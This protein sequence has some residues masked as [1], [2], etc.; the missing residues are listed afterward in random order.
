MS[1]SMRN[2]DLPRYVT[3]RLGTSKFKVSVYHDGKMHPVGYAEQLTDAVALR[4]KYCQEHNI[5]VL[6]PLEMQ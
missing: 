1:K 4:D 6:D 2:R 5:V 3:R